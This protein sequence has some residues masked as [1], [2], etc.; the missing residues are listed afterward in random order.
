LHS[1]GEHADV[2]SAVWSLPTLQVATELI[3]PVFEYA[4]R[5]KISLAL[6]YDCSDLNVDAFAILGGGF[7]T[8]LVFSEVKATIEED[9]S[10]I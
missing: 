2:G 10:D 8:H 4:Y 3:S 1:I 5:S 6:D 9:I 7:E